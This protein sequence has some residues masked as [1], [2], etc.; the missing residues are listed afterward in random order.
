VSRTKYRARA[1][2]GIAGKL[3]VFRANTRTKTATIS[4]GGWLG[5]DTDGVKLFYERVKQWPYA[6]NRTSSVVVVVLYYSDRGP[7]P[8]KSK[9]RG[10]GRVQTTVPKR[11]KNPYELLLRAGKLWESNDVRAVK[12]GR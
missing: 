2:V 11:N 6:V 9:P 4:D 10:N 7:C 3:L 1:R 8:S 5:N 12:R